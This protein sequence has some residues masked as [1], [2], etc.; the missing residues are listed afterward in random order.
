M[1][2]ALSGKH[3]TAPG[4]FASQHP[5]LV[6]RVQDP[7]QSAVEFT[8]DDSIGCNM[9]EYDGYDVTV[10][11][12]VLTLDCEHSFNSLEIVNGGSL[13]HSA[14]Q[15][16]GLR[17]NIATNLII[18]DTSTVDVNGR[19]FAPTQGPGA[20]SASYCNASGEPFVGQSSSTC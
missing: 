20:G 7:P 13:T 19:G 12:A 11:G 9:L 6:R 4:P 2:D 18:D 16:E 5:S 8:V 17:L 15:V 1:D 3:A 10:N 14:V